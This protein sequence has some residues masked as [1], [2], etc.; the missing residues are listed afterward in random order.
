MSEGL[1]E[2]FLARLLDD[3]GPPPDVDWER[4][5][6]MQLVPGTAGARDVA[7]REALV[8]RGLVELAQGTFDAETERR[9]LI[10]LRTLVT[11]ILGQRPQMVPGFEN[12]L[13]D[14]LSR[15]AAPGTPPNLKRM[16]DGVAEIVRAADAITVRS[17]ADPLGE[18]MMTLLFI[19][20]RYVG[21][22]PASQALP[23]SGARA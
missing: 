15:A 23:S 20:G 7:E 14:T 13:V 8:G 18:R 10:S 19:D 22:L 16:L 21:F 2:A 5:R 12:P 11:Q 6:F 1:A 17:E 4:Y 9:S 3:K